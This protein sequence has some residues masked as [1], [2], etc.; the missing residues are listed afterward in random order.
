MKGNVAGSSQE[1]MYQPPRTK[2]FATAPPY[3]PLV[4]HN[5]PILSAPELVSFYWGPFSD[6]EMGTMQSWLMS[7]ASFLSGAQAPSRHEPVVRQYGIMG[8]T[9]GRSYIDPVAPNTTVGCRKLAIKS[10]VCRHLVACHLSG[11]S[12][13]F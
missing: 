3:T 10:P 7:F 6:A 13:S 8:A 4:Y 1:I 2:V 5:G 11:H 12:G 9:V